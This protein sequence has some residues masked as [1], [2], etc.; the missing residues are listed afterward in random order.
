MRGRKLHRASNF[1]VGLRAAER[2]YAL[3]LTRWEPEMDLN[4]LYH[5]HGHAL[6]MA[7]YAACDRSQAAHLSMAEAY[8]DRIAATLVDLRQEAA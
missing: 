6:L 2:L 4:Y 3:P 5:R 1:S 7:E 8:S